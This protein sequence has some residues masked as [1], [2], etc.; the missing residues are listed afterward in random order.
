MASL[1]LCVYGTPHG[2]D[3][4]EA[5]PAMGEYYEQFYR[6][7]RRGRMLMAN[8]R[9]DGSTIYSFL[10]YDLIENDL[11]QHAFF[12]TSF[13]IR[14]NQYIPDLHS[15]YALFDTIFDNSL[16]NGQL[17]VAASGKLKY[18][19]GKFN[20]A[21]EVLADYL[22]KIMSGLANFETE[23]YTADF[24]SNNSG[25]IAL[26]N[27]DT[28][29]NILTDTFKKCQWLAV[30]PY[31][32]PDDPG[33][34][35]DLGDINQQYTTSLESL[36]QMSIHKHQSEIDKIVNIIN[37][38]NSS[39]QL[40]KKYA[41]QGNLDN[42]ELQ[43]IN[44]LSVKLNTLRTNAT[45]LKSQIEQ[46][47]SQTTTI[48]R[49]TDTYTTRHDGAQE[50]S[51]HVN[52]P[53][54]KLCIKC[55]REKLLSAFDKDS[56]ICRE[57][58]Y[59]PFWKKI[60]PTM[61]GIAAII[62]VIILISWILISPN[63]EP[64]SGQGPTPP[65]DTTIVV[66]NASRFAEALDAGNL[67][68]ALSCIDETDYES[69][70]KIGERFEK[71]ARDKILASEGDAETQLRYYL[72]SEPHT[73]EQFVVLVASLKYTA[74]ELDGIYSQLKATELSAKT[75]RELK[76]KINELDDIGDLQAELIA[77]VD[78]IP[79]PQTPPQ[80]SQGD[81]T[82]QSKLKSPITLCTIGP[83]EKVLDKRNLKSDEKT[84]SLKIGETYIIESDFDIKIL[85]NGKVDKRRSLRQLTNKKI[86]IYN[87]QKNSSKISI[88]DKYY[89][90][91]IK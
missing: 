49:R 77:R 52:I 58:A 59:V 41:A 39:L 47:N 83:G 75:K 4:Y 88:G 7:N 12:G 74:K 29:T 89:D 36:M 5:P 72:D 23:Y 45:A 60:D 68:E 80:P 27:I 19:V 78:K 26:K 46:Y 37:S 33:I 15:L 71:D 62:L 2:F 76:N 70:K 20:T 10:V 73:A 35:I 56:D 85:I 14:G 24:L 6:T 67:D 66:D 48:T 44:D 34:E 64:Q 84:I 38:T 54:K 65:T 25:Q 61:A 30:S 42:D 32:K 91:V 86:R 90:I 3:S 21:A 11:R 28:P 81:A 53:K 69:L 57:C 82:N 50:N 22:S 55:G 63:K 16:T 8:R 13:I 17:F 51:V 31:F 1:D 9:N 87:T 43:K 18:T 79:S 40:M